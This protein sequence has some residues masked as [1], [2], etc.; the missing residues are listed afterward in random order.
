MIAADWERDAGVEELARVIHHADE[1]GFHYIGVCDHIALPEELCRRMG[2]FWP[3]CVGT[4]SWAARHDHPYQPALARVRAPLPSPARRGQAVLD[5]RLPVGRSCHR[6]DRRRSRAARSSSGSTSTSAPARQARRRE[7]ARAD[8][9]A[10]ARS[11]STAIG[12]SPRP[13]QQPRPPV[14]VAGSSPAA[15]RR[16]ARLADGWLPQGPSDDERWSRVARRHASRAG[17][18]DQP[19]MIGH[20]T[21]WLYVGKPELGRAR[22]V[23]HRRTAR[24]RRADPRPAPPTA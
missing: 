14:W 3:D 10:G 2:T 24:S 18:A 9:R 17:R 11:G 1:H 23:A 7:G 6:R 16:A 15:I 20:I 12:A 22:R 19:M 4:L 21:P 5:A 8:Q 13:V